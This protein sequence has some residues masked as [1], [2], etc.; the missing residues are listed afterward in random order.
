MEF[1]NLTKELKVN[2]RLKIEIFPYKNRVDGYLFVNEL[3]NLFTNCSDGN[4]IQ[5]GSFFDTNFS[6]FNT[7]INPRTEHRYK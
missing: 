5:L 7:C 1:E 2:S 4:Y 6:D 3:G